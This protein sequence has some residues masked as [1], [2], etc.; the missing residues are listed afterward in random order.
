MTDIPLVPE[1][2]RPL[3]RLSAGEGLIAW[4]ASVDHKQIG[5]MY[6]VASFLFFGVGG[7][8][9]LL[10]RTQLMQP[11][12]KFLSP[13]A[14]NQIF[15]MHG[16]TMI[17]LVVVPLLIGFVTYLVPLMIGARDMLFPRLN[18][19]S[20]WMLVFGGLLLYY[21]FLGGGAPM[22]LCHLRSGHEATDAIELHQQTALVVT[23]D[24]T[25]NDAAI[26]L[27]LGCI[28]PIACNL[29]HGERK[30]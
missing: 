3:P 6:I 18:A 14:Y 26:A 19:L 24:L 21:S 20:F 29:N 4:I 23:N 28:L 8:E 9:A 15:T 5:I 16:T 22:Q 12:S 1:S 11:N 10:M 7:V 27:Q 17:F 25:L 13:E 30:N 2:T